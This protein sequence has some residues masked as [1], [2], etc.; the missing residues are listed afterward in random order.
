MGIYNLLLG[1]G[2]GTHK[3]KLIQKILNLKRKSIAS[4]HNPLVYVIFSTSIMD[5]KK[6]QVVY[7]KGMVSFIL[8]SIPNSKPQFTVSGQPT[9]IF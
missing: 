1:I 4:L 6:Y 2:V 9:A 7:I 3:N 5:R 8:D